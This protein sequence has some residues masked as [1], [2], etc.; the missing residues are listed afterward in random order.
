MFNSRMFTVIWAAAGITGIFTVLRQGLYDPLRGV[1]LI[2]A[3]FITF[4][5]VVPLSLGI[6]KRYPQKYVKAIQWVI[7]LLWMG[8]GCTMVAY[9]FVERK[10]PYHQPDNY[11]GG[12][13]AVLGLVLLTAAPTMTIY[14]QRNRRRSEEK[15]PS[16]K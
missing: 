4:S 15:R 16:C 13:F 6:G 1:M 5:A 14:V 10:M 7:S 9:F 3:G 11:T 2:M 8:L 12:A